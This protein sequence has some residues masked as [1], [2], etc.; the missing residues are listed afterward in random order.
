MKISDELINSINESDCILI[1]FGEEF[2]LADEDRDKLISAYDNIAKFCMSK[3]YFV[4]NICDDDLIFDS[5]FDK[6]RIAAPF[7][8]SDDE[9]TNPFDRESNPI[10]D[11]YMKWL[12]HTLN[13]RLL[14]LEFGCLTGS[15]NIVRWPFEKT[16]MLNQKSRLVRIN[17]N[18]PFVPAE[19]SE[20]A[21][22]V[23]CNSVDYL[24]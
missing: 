21:S 18:C 16:V 15:M 24:I 7:A 17:E 2:R 5:S 1:A 23:K 3:N 13:N 8:H 12:S 22:S 6:E 14:I 19:I 11:K 20:R 10:W 4:V 9:S